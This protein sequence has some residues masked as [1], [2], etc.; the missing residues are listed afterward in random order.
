MNTFYRLIEFM[1]RNIGGFSPLNASRGLIRFNSKTHKNTT[2]SRAQS[3]RTE[4]SKHLSLHSL[5]SLMATR[6]PLRLNSGRAAA[7]NLALQENFTQETEGSVKQIL[8]SWGSVAQR[9]FS[10]GDEMS[11]YDLGGGTATVTGVGNSRAI[12]AQAIFDIIGKPEIWQNLKPSD[13]TSD[14]AKLEQLR[15]LFESQTFKDLKKHGMPHHSIGLVDAKNPSAKQAIDFDKLISNPDLLMGF[16]AAVPVE[17]TID[18]QGN[19]VYPTAEE[20]QSRLIPTYEDPKHNTRPSNAFVIPLEWL[21][22]NV[23]TPASSIIGDAA[24]DPEL[25]SSW[26]IEGALE[27]G[28]KFVLPFVH[29]STK[30]ETI[31]GDTAQTREQALAKSGLKPAQFQTLEELVALKTLLLKKVFAKLGF[32]FQDAKFELVCDPANQETFAGLKFADG[33]SADEMRLRRLNGNTKVPFSKQLLRLIMSKAQV[34]KIVKAAKKEATTRQDGTTFKQILEAKGFTIPV[35]QEEPLALIGELYETMAEAL[36]EYAQTGK[37]GNYDFE[38]LTARLQTKILDRKPEE[39][40]TPDSWAAHQSYLEQ[41]P[42][43][44]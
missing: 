1:I 2:A 11:V 38:A 44:A 18:E 9:Y 5:N 15:P 43:A 14:P 35:I 10:V 21:A 20:L 24:K 7:R 25:A 26:G 34:D 19:Y 33:T 40:F 17:P 42:I 29:A 13:F 23:L 30:R 8:S 37:A 4:Q 6:Q 22:R 16:Q 41:Y 36:Y 12:F 39:L 31:A 27:A 28:R 32:D 3:P